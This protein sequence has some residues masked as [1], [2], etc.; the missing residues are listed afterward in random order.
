MKIMRIAVPLVIAIAL[1][2]ATEFFHLDGTLRV[3]VWIV[4]FLVAMIST[5]VF[6]VK[7]RMRRLAEQQAKEKERGGK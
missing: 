3:I 1:V 6:D 5:A 2:I 7:I 4:G